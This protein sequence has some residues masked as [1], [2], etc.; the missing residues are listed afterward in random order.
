MDLAPLF[1]K[2][3]DYGIFSAKDYREQAFSRNIGLFTPQEQEKLAEAR[4]GIP[5][6]G[7]VGG[8]HLMTMVRTGVTNFHISDFDIY[9]PVNVNR[10]FGARVP[11]FGRPKM[12]VMKEEALSVNP[13]LN[14]REFPEGINRDT[15]DEF[16]EGVD[17]VLDSL[18]FFAFDIRRLLF[19]RAREKGVHVITAGPLGFSSAMLIF[20]PDKGMGFDDYFNIIDGMKPEDQHLFFALGLA[21]KRLQLRYMDT[22]R[23]S[24]KSKKGPSLDLACQLCSA[25]AGTEAV[26]IILGRKG[27]KPVPYYFQFDPF[28]QKYYRKKL[29]LGNKNIIQQAVIRLARKMI[30]KN[31]VVLPLSTLKKP[32][33]EIFEIQSGKKQLTRAAREY[34]LGR[35]ILAP[36]ADNCQPYIFSWLEGDLLIQSDPERTHF[37][38]D[39]NQESTLITFGAVVENIDIG[40]RDLGLE[41]L[42]DKVTLTKK[43]EVSLR[44]QFREKSGEPDSLAPFVDLRCT[45]RKPYA[46]TS[47]EPELLKKMDE[48]LGSDPDITMTWIVGQE[49]KK[50]FQEIVY[51][52]D[53]VLF[54][55]KRLHQGL[56][57]FIHMGDDPYPEDGMNLGVLELSWLQKKIFP[58]FMQWKY[59][60]LLNKLLISRAMAMN[61][62]NLLKRTPVYGMLTL[63][64]RS[65]L[66]YVE[67]GRKMERFWISAN[68]LGLA[69]QPM[70]GFV[71]LLNHYHYNQAQYFQPVHQKMIAEMQEMF[72]TVTGGAGEAANPVMFFRLGY[73]PPPTNRTGRRPLVDV[74]K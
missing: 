40:A 44:V 20:A 51:L 1:A 30:E 68:S 42:L 63:K 46:Q 56:F 59:Q 9:E 64:T 67:A 3:E 43:G 31:E 52:S 5:G 34:V 27:L 54:E 65:P 69:V 29:Y 33:G 19:N 25:M 4:V 24:F 10:Q 72:A 61:S 71:F 35:G 55:E 13:Y 23:V 22:S 41:A 8:V 57:E 70:A 21:P 50:I 39:V 28:I 60:N 48:V 16:L 53:R 14:I 7:G 17:V 38:Y 11:D 73:A 36:S 62:V 37:F 49:E 26:R 32:G 15:V 74:Q 66:D 2:L 47:I 6:M 18:D 45:N 12:E 58:L